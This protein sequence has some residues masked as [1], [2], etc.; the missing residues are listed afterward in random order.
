MVTSENYAD[1]EFMVIHFPGDGGYE[2]LDVSASEDGLTVT[3]GIYSP[4]YFLYR[5]AET[6]A[7]PDQ[8][9]VPFPDD[10][11]YVPLPPTIVYEDDGSDSTASI[12]AC[13]AAA[14]VAAILAIVLAST[15]RRK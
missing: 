13:A 10:D 11:D 9:V 3:V 4:F 12:A 7:E 8:P 2:N 14:V 1:Y 15:Y 5:L 6:E